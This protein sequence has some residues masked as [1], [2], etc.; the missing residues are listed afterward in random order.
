MNHLFTDS[1]SLIGQIAA[2][3]LIGMLVFDHIQ[4]VRYASMDDDED[5]NGG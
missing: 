1:V 3:V 2:G 5:E 4:M